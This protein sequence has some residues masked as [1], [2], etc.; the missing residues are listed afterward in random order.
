MRI[1]PFERLIRSELARLRHL[2]RGQRRHASDLGDTTRPEAVQPAGRR[3]VPA[4]EAS[5]FR[6]VGREKSR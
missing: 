3:A 5:A 4:T 6:R 2:A 1:D